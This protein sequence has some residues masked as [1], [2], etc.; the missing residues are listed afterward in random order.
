MPTPPVP[1]HC[2][3]PLELDDLE[4]LTIGAL[5]PT[6]RRSTSRAARSRCALPDAV[7][8]QAAPAG[9]VELVDPE[10]CPLARVAWPGG[11]GRAADPRAVRPVPPALPHPG[12][13]RRAVRRPHRRPGHRRRSPTPSS[14]S[15]PGSARSPCW[16]WSAPAP[17]RCPRSACSAPPCA[18]AGAA[19]GRRRRRRP[20]RRRTATP[21]PTRRWGSRSSPTTPAGDRGR[22]A[23]AD[24]EDGTCPDRGRRHR[25]RA[26][27]RHRTSR[28][29]SSSSP[30]SPAAASPRSPGP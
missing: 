30:A 4:L 19:A 14:T 16:P 17:R 27:A 13:V 6:R 12:D 22:T 8:A 28:A 21:R 2:P 9:A 10:G 15:W 24:D 25:R 20:P 11:V 7:A 23:L 26:T 3:S 1:Q 29:W 18:A 5:A